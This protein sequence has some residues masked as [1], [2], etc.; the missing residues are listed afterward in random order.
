MKRILMA[1]ATA[2]LFATSF[3]LPSAAQ[4]QVRVTDGNFTP[5]PLAIPDF[6]ISGTNAE[7]AKQISDVV[8]ADLTSTGL[9]EMQN[10]ASFIQKDLSLDVQPRFADWKIINT[11]ALVVGQY[12]ELPDGKIAVSF[13]L[14]PTPS[15]R[16]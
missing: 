16:A 11:D 5:T 6:Q 4:L 2:F 1:L 9:F 14:W 7:L 12:E 10:P 3:A 8:R 13:R 15:I